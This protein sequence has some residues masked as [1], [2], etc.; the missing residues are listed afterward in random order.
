[1]RKRL[2]IGFVPQDPVSAPGKTVEQVLEEALESEHDATIV[3]RT[4]APEVEVVEAGLTEDQRGLRYGTLMHAVLAVVDFTAPDVARVAALQ[5][6]ILGATAEEVESVVRVVSSVVRH[7][8]IERAAR[9]RDLRRE[10]P[11]TLAAG[12][13]LIEGVADLAF[14]DDGSWTVVDFKTDAEIGSRLPS[15][16]RQVALYARAIAEATGVRAVPVL[17]RL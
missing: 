3:G 13:T 2:R 1:V 4:L 10:V 7:P 15:Y 5:G 14:L 16:K 12:E 6:R 8:L 17:F 11:L 9:A